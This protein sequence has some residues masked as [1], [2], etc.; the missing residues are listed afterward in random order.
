[1]RRRI[2]VTAAT[3]ALAAAAT[4]PALTASTP[5][6]GTTVPTLQQRAREIAVQIGAANAKLQVLSEEYDQAR[7]RHAALG[8]QIAADRAAL[9]DARS[10]VARDAHNLQDQA[11]AA[12]VTA[13]SAP[14]L[15]VLM[16]GS[17]NSLPLQ[18]T[19]L[20][21]A[22]GSL[23]TA[24]TSLHDSEHRLS[25]RESTLGSAQSRAAAS[26]RTLATSRSTANT[27]LDQLSTTQQ[28]LSG[29]LAAAV[30]A[31]E[32]IQSAQAAARAAAQQA[33][34]PTVAQAAA[35]PLPPSI[36]AATSTPPSGGQGDAAVHAAE[37]QLGVPY[38][39]A[40]S[41]PGQGF[42]CSGLTMWAWAQAGVNLPHS[43]QAQ[44]DGIEH[45]SLD[46]L[47]PGDL[48]FYASGGYIYHVTMYVGGGEMVQ[49]EDTGTVIQVTPVW[50]GAY[51]AG[52]P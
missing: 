40:G 44:Y 13:G 16:T 42:D 10:S 2:A 41:A 17:V 11:V 50:P 38:V 39:W 4:V 30:A 25:V 45:V 35:Q 29:Q 8:R 28:Q 37:T 1:V 52:R 23:S 7:L 48:I 34:A 49:A 19:Y 22:S 18:Q 15:S 21:A 43:A 51:G 3:V 46:A 9:G 5:A 47:Q 31:Q 36:P 26:E 32:R 6:S 24:V 12:Y 27:L 20:Q 33:A 14:G